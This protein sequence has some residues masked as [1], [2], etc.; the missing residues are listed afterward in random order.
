MS[1]PAPEMVAKARRVIVL[2]IVIGVLVAAGFFFGKSQWHALSASFGAL[3]SILSTMW[4]RRGVVK[5]G[6]RAGNGKTGEAILY[7][8]AALRFLM[9][10]VLFAVGLAIIKLAP[11]AT[12]AGFVL[13]QLAFAASALPEWRKA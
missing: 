13:T 7:I 6:V 8:N 12:V 10:L 9:I 3:I 11:V 1:G 2:Q 4:L 5:A